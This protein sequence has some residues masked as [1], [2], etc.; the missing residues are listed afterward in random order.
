MNKYLIL[1]LGLFLIFSCNDDD[2]QSMNI[3]QENVMDWYPL[4]VG[5]FWVYDIRRQDDDGEFTL[6][7]GQ[8]TLTVAGDTMINGQ[9]YSILDWEGQFSFPDQ[10]LRDSLDY[11]VDEKG[12]KIFSHS[13]S[14]ELLAS[15][16]EFIVSTE[17]FMV[18]DTTVQFD[19]GEFESLYTRETFVV[20]SIVT[21]Q[22]D[23]EDLQFWVK[24]I[25]LVRDELHYHSQCEIIRR[26]LADYQ[27]K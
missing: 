18:G 3:G 1:A 4:S 27:I 7:T 15:Y 13:N 8:D 22:C 14:M 24:D 25:G 11:I 16:S 23:L 19:F 20:D 10:Y 26:E 6:T 2:D 12:N 21:S 9:L 5:S 17:V